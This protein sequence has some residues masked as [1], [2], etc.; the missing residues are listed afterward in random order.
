MSKKTVPLT[1]RR[2]SGAGVPRE[3]LRGAV[4]RPQEAEQTQRPLGGPA[5]HGSRCGWNWGLNSRRYNL[6]SI[7]AGNSEENRILFFFLTSYPLETAVNIRRMFWLSIK[8][9]F[10]VLKPMSLFHLSTPVGCPLFVRRGEVKTGLTVG[11]LPLHPPLCD[12]TGT[13]SRRHLLHQPASMRAKRVAQTKPRPLL[14]WE[15]I[16]STHL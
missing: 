9:C 15:P 7:N 16:G 10:D 6:P 5:Q 12:A 3:V 13:R 1:W 2:R 4:A 14:C 8:K 11:P